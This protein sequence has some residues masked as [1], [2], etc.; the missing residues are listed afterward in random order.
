[1]DRTL[2]NS[3]WRLADGT[4]RPRAALADQGEPDGAVKQNIDLIAERGF[5][6]LGVP[7]DCGGLGADETTQHEYT[8]I[9]ASVCG[10]TAFTQQQFRV[11]IKQV[12]EGDN[13]PLRRN[14][15]PA[16]ATGRL[17]SGVALSQLR[18]SGAPLLT[19]EPV[20]GGFCLNGTIPWIT[21]WQLLDGFV[22]GAALDGGKQHLFAYI[23]IERHRESLTPSALLPLVVMRAS[24]TV[25]IEVRDLHVRYA[26]VLAVRPQEDLRLAD[27][28]EITLHTALPLGCARASERYLRDL[29]QQQ[30]REDLDTAATALMFEINHCRREALTWNCECVSHPEYRVNALR[31]R[32]NAIV[33]AVRAAHAAVT[34]GGG[35]AQLVTA[36]PQRLLREAQFYTTAVQTPEVQTSVLQQLFSPLYGM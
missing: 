5:L 11:A 8:E 24:G 12:A 14:L 34:A 2:L 22:V 18:R 28:R 29:A 13:D 19:A 7:R 15:L 1:M 27:E 23:E 36:T 3:L 6:G 20:T 31:A 32:G 21:G 10:V 9:L 35:G 25:A 16:L 26:E 33:L 4:I 17:Y 30:D